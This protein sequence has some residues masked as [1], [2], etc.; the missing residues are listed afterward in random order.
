ML[1]IYS[2]TFSRGFSCRFF[3]DSLSNKKKRKKRGSTIE[4]DSCIQMT[5]CNQL[6]RNSLTQRYYLLDLHLMNT[7]P[8]QIWCPMVFNW[9][10]VCPMNE[11]MQQEDLGLLIYFK[12]KKNDKKNYDNFK[13]KKRVFHFQIWNISSFFVF[14]WFVRKL[15]LFVLCQ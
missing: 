15:F 11:W 3:S 1:K 7:N 10:I 2:Q 8:Y 4:E 9:D 5:E 6:I 14:F 13:K 12:K